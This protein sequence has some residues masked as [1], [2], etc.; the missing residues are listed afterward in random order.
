MSAD[1]AVRI[2]N[3]AGSIVLFIGSYR[4]QRWTRQQADT[5][6]EAAVAPAPE[7]TPTPAAAPAAAKKPAGKAP[8]AK[9]GDFERAGADVAGRPFFDRPAYLLFCVGFAIS[10]VASGIDL[11]SHHSLAHLWDAVSG[12]AAASTPAEPR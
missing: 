12:Q 7:S 9:P 10:T 3:L 1:D 8:L 11:C 5:E 6:E 2:L 4:G